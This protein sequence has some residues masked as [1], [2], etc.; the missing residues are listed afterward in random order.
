MQIFLPCFMHSTCRSRCG[1]S[2]Q[3]LHCAQSRVDGHLLLDPTID[4]A[5][6]EDGSALLAMMPSANAVRISGLI[7]LFTFRSDTLCLADVVYCSQSRDHNN[8]VPH[9]NLLVAQN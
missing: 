4:E 2:E 7:F 6:R 5:Y 1:D 3:A 8:V 9:A